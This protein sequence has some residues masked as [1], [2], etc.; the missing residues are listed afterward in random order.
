MPGAGKLQAVKSTN[1]ISTRATLPFLPMRGT[2]SLK[3][4]L[5]PCGVRRNHD[6]CAP[7]G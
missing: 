3:V 5:S 6:G 2:S 7:D 1:G 4:T